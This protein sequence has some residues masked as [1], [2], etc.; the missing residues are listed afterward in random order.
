M[1]D[2]WTDEQF[3]L[4]AHWLVKA[5]E[6]EDARPHIANPWR[7]KEMDRA[8]QLCEIFAKETG[9][10]LSMELNTPFKCAGIIRLEGKPSLF[11][12]CQLFT[13]ICR[14]ASNVGMDPHYGSWLEIELTFYGIAEPLMGQY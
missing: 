6:A 3:Q 7:L 9:M 4:I 2:E 5:M 12:N 1:E 14:Y 10:E 13:D 8:Y 11:K